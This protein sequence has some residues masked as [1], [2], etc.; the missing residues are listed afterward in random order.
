MTLDI[1]AH[2]KHHKPVL[3]LRSNDMTIT[4][5]N[6]PVTL[7]DFHLVKG[8]P[9]QDELVTLV[10]DRFRGSNAKETQN[11]AKKIMRMVPAEGFSFAIF[12]FA[13]RL[14]L[15]QGFTSNRATLE[16]AIFTETNSR[17]ERM[18]S[19]FTQ[20][21][22]VVTDKAEPAR[23][24]AAAEAQKNLLSI[25]HNGTDLSGAHVDITERAQ[26]K[27]L[28]SALQES[29]K[30]MQ[31]QHGRPALAGLL[32]LVR[33][34]QKIGGRKSIVY[35]TQNMRLDA[36][37]KDMVRSIT[38][39]ATQAG[40][41]FYIVDM[42]ALN[43]GAE[44][45]LQTAMM[46]GSGQPFNTA[47]IPVAGSGGQAATTPMQQPSGSSGFGGGL[48]DSTSFMMRSDEYAMFSNAIKNP[49]AE[50]AT[51]TG[52]EYIDAQN[53]LSR[54]LHT[55]LTDFTT[56]YEASYIPPIK[57]YDG[58]FRTIAI[59]PNYKGLDVR[60]KTGYF[61]VAPGAEAGTRPFEVPLLK[62]LTETPL[63]SEFQFNSSILRFGDVGG[64]DAN[65]VAVNVPLSQL[66]V[67][68]DTRTNLFLAHASIVAQI[69]DKAGVLVEHF[70]DD[71]VRR[72]GLETLSRD[73]LES[74]SLQRNFIAGP[75]KYSLE[76]AVQDRLS[77]KS[78]A[79]RI[80]F[81]I[82]DVA[83]GAPS[84]SDIALVRRMEAI[85]ENDD[86]TLEPLRYQRGSVIANVSGQLPADAKGV[87]LYFILHP[88]SA[89]TGAATLQM[90]VVHNGTPGRRMPL[91]LTIKPGT[92]AVRYLASFGSGALSPGAYEVRAYLDQGGKTVSQS[93]HFNVEGK[94]GGASPDGKEITETT[95]AA[96]PAFVPSS[97]DAKEPGELTITVPKDPM[98]PL[99]AQEAH[100][101]LED[102]GD[103][104]LKYNDSL[105]NFMCVEV[106][107]RSVDPSGE[108]RWKL[109][110]NFVE[111]MRYHDKQES[112]TTLE[113]NG[114]R[115]TTSHAAM[116]GSLSEGEFGGVLR[117]VFSP[118]ADTHFQWRETN[119]LNGGLV[120]VFDYKVERAHSMFGVV[121]SDNRELI[122]GF[123][124][125]VFID[126]STHSVRRITVIADDLPATF[127]TH[128]SSLSVDYD[129][130]A[131]DKH[132]YLLPIGAEMRLIKGRHYN[133][134]N[135]IEF[136][137]YRR[138]GSQSRILGFTPVDEAKPPKK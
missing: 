8:K 100:Q 3:N 21:V 54:P 128:Y 27:V 60:S 70:G 10:F 44:Y 32:G 133:T 36:A 80:D 119:E 83:A 137:S 112:R 79:R 134:L 29:Q 50:L 61:A 23:I 71:Q 41:T 121:G 91:P 113:V 87:S 45:Q 94:P 85:H 7:K 110:D 135:T 69:R 111:L 34:Q 105:P 108:G 51:A 53:S 90:Q 63:P 1:V 103:R 98:P 116:A 31:E 2:D 101:L 82:P 92:E 46:N 122:T 16:S 67:Q 76:V 15:I 66:E 20:E 72:G 124:G 52:G 17:P 78:S 24:K 28:L 65:T 49:L 95:L 88:S 13:G 26:Y 14:R 75:G 4:D 18:E 129:Y 22:N 114:Q 64:V 117:S 6:A 37:G 127:S 11:I 96:G 104:A 19:T 25:I 138:Y 120:Q 126:S 130:V 39:A 109:Q 9:S 62:D 77:G 47:S 40:V 107:N 33:A 84:F 115:S 38:G 97:A 35:F 55:M 74:I 93:I 106:T 5:E 123:H 136:R 81:E 68:K 132:D 99:G 86:D 125:Q 73:P 102:A 43:A 30:A 56:Y 118:T 89:G 58:S 48:A 59:K 42:D 57:D 131:I 12:D